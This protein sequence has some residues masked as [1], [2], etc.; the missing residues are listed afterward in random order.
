MLLAPWA[1]AVRNCERNS[2]PKWSTETKNAPYNEPARVVGNHHN[3][4]C[5]AAENQLFAAGSIMVL[6]LNFLWA[7]HPQWQFSVPW[8]S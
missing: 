1:A 2:N 5:Y 3:M 8:R 6:V 7:E 4:Q